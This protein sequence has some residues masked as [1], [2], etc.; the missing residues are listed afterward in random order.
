ML[1]IP[2][3]ARGIGGALARMMVGGDYGINLV[4]RTKAGKDVKLIASQYERHDE[5]IQKVAQ[6]CGKDLEQMPMGMFT[7][8]WPQ[9]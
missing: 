6:A 8:S 2:I 3:V 1:R 7:W 5:I 4:V 9:R